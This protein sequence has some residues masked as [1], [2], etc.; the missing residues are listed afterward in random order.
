[1]SASMTAE[2]TS[3]QNMRSDS[4]TIAAWITLTCFQGPV[5]FLTSGHTPREVPSM[6]D[7][8][9]C[10]IPS[11]FN[12]PA[13]GASSRNCG[14]LQP[15]TTTPLGE[16]PVA[17]RGRKG[18]AMLSKSLAVTCWSNS[19]AP[20]GCSPSHSSRTGVWLWL[21]KG[22]AKNTTKAKLEKRWEQTLVHKGLRKTTAVFQSVVIH[23][24]ATAAMT[25]E[26]Q[27]RQVR[28]RGYGQ[29]CQGAGLH[30]QAPHLP[31]GV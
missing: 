4:Q 27:Q 6:A 30:G 28:L 22:E 17:P 10:M 5:V 26:S 25:S 29:R 2:M 12:R 13:S 19:W 14:D 1:M 21:E 11:R 16:E 7:F 31:P 20:R 3:S 18:M 15:A 8:H 9:V 24:L 23:W